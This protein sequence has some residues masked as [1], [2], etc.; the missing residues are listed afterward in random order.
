[1][2]IYLWLFNNS[3]P[4]AQQRKAIAGFT[5]E[6]RIQ[7]NRLV[8]FSSGTLGRTPACSNNRRDMQEFPLV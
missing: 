7:V 2:G 3:M 5:K 4:I 6:L 8:C 1:M